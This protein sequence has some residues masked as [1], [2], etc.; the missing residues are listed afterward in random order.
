MIHPGDTLENHVTG[1]VLVFRRTSAQTNGE[2]VLF[3]TIVRPDGFV[4]AAHV[5]PNQTERFEIVQGA[6]ALRVGS[7]E[8][9]LAPGE[10]AVVPPGTPHRFWNA[11]QEEARFVCE[12]R[13]ALGFESLIETMFVL[14]A[15]GKTNK[16]GLPN[17]FRLAVIAQAHF[18]TV[19]L[20]FPPASL[21]RAALAVGAPLGKL[22]GYRETTTRRPVD[23]RP[24]AHPVRTY[25]RGRPDKAERA[26]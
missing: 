23:T 17:P 8:L 26:R 2:S 9:L 24:H 3:E 22:L 7:D 4:A 15:E 20:P 13:P 6:L 11:G 12:V 5:H 19:R 18:D 21:Q 14:A 16:K 25:D 10:V 1:E